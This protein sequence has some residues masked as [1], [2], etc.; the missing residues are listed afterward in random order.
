MSA[1]AVSVSALAAITLLGVAALGLWGCPQYRVYDQR[2]SGRAELE[3][4][5]QNRQVR[6]REAQAA[7]DAAQLTAQAEV[8]KARGV[9]EANQIMASSLAGPEAEAYLRW[10]YIE[11]LEETSGQGD[12]QSIIYIPTEAG[13]PILEAGRFARPPQ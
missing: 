5:D 10:R 12:H 9:A 1:G 4:A 11:M 13:I 7:L 3:R 6:V 8:A 2:M